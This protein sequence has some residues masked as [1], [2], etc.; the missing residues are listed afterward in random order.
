VLE[1]QSALFLSSPAHFC[2]AQFHLPDCTAAKKPSETRG[3]HKVSIGALPRTG[4]VPPTGSVGPAP[5]VN[6]DGFIDAV[7]AALVK[8]KSGTALP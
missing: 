4:P 2:S 1:L 5:G 6:V 7:D 8:S 3:V